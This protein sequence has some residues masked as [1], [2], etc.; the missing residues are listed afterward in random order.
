MVCWLGIG[1]GRVVSVFDEIVRECLGI[2]GGRVVSV[3]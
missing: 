3:F 1:G 2:G